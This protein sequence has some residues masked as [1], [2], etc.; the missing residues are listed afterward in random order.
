MLR[1]YVKKHIWGQT[2]MSHATSLI[3]TKL[4]IP[5]TRRDLVLRPRLTDRLTEGLSRPLTLISAPAGFGKST[6]LGEWRATP[7]GRAYPLAW[8]SL[9]PE[10]GDPLRF[11]TYVTAALRTL[12]A[13]AAA[14]QLGRASMELLQNHPA[15]PP[16]GYLP[17]LLNEL[18]AGEAPFALVLDDYHAIDSAAVHDAMHFLIDHLHRGMHLVLLTRADPPWPLARLRSQGLLS[19]FRAADLRFTDREAAAFFARVLPGG[20]PEADVAAL[21][22]RTEGWAAS[23]QMAALSLAGQQGL[24]ERH[25]FVTAFAGEHRYVADY[26]AEEVIARQ[27]EP[28]QEFLMRTAILERMTAPLCAAVTGQDDAE[29]WLTY[30]DR[31]N[32]FLIP[33]D[34][35]RR[36]FRYHHL[37]ADLLRAR[38]RRLHPELL[39]TLC[40]RASRWHE[41]AGDPIPAVTFAL[42]AA[43]H[44]RAA[45]LVEQNVHGWWGLAS[46]DFLRLMA[47]LPAAVIRTR[48]T[49]A[50]YQA[51]IG[52]VTGRLDTAMPLI[53]AA[54]QQLAAGPD[55]QQIAMRSFLA[56]MRTYIMEM[57]EQPYSLSPDVLQAPGF[58]PATQVAMRNSAD[59][60]LSHILF[61]NGDSEGAADHLLAAAERDLAA[62]LTNAVPIA[63]SQLARIRVL[64][65]RLAEAG[66][67]CRRHLQ[68][69][70]LRGAGRYFING[71]LNGALADVLREQNDL[72]GAE[73]Q[74]RAGLAQNERWSIPDALAGSWLCLARVLMARGDLEGADG[75]LARA[76]EYTRGHVSMADLPR[77]QAAVQ[78]RLWLARGN[79]AA[80]RQWADS[81][82]LA[83]DA[84]VSF[85]HEPEHLALARILLA[86]GRWSEA[87]A[88][89]TRLAAAA[90]AGG[91]TGRL[92]EMLVLEALALRQ[93]EPERA[94]TTL[95]Q[96]LVLTEPSGQVRAFLDEG[97]PMAALLQRLAERSGPT[98]GYATRLLAAC[99]TADGGP[100]PA[101]RLLEPLS[102]RELEVLRL[103][104]AGLSNQEMAD[105]LVVSVGT[106][107]TH[108]HH[109]YGKLAADSRTR[110]IA[111]ARELRLI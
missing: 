101:E 25:A 104:A 81:R 43:Q 66:E 61:M 99:S 37:F 35:D 28:V 36:W 76:G 110:A 77:L 16:R 6:L 9:E 5:P 14:G 67:V 46:G 103:L 88:L 52:I 96:A 78:V 65:G 22:Q 98:R 4:Y 40:A 17:P 11:W 19:E 55:T 71:S 24:A 51:W 63:I 21:Q 10:D 84:P 79:V 45:L 91:R 68:I 83:V 62:G 26:L 59:V 82:G 33:L 89:L 95:G 108:V 49:L 60:V 111:R 29:A 31:A 80:A 12:P 13:F 41:A 100:I 94:L 2:A 73:E 57:R 32:L 42:A 70:G 48:P 20:L 109:I 38:L 3:S 92:V 54:E 74:A 107:K 105:R 64:Q 56:L 53:E 27:P 23:L 85:R 102:D 1:Y 18:A 87:R 39:P 58:I 97:K 8:L 93:H 75:A 30:I 106:V 69:I 34:D 44:D 86:E 47:R 72:V 15:M 7:A 50:V 90:A